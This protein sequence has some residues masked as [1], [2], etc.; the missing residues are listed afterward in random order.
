M[1]GNHRITPVDGVIAAKAKA[2]RVSSGKS[3]AEVARHL[4]VAYQSYAELEKGN[5]SIRVS[6][7]VK[8]SELHGVP[9]QEF[10]RV[11]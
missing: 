8:L 3:K 9:V 10:L 11:A 2:L 5:V 4:D 7:L 6:A 1:S